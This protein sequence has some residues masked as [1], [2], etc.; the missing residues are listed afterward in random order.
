MANTTSKNYRIQFLEASIR[1]AKRLG[2]TNRIEE[3][4][5]QIKQLEPLA[6]PIRD[7][8][9]DL[10]TYLAK[11]QNYLEERDIVLAVFRILTSHARYERLHWLQIRDDGLLIERFQ[12]DRL[13]D[14]LV[15][16]TVIKNSIL[17]SWLA[18][19]QTTILLRRDNFSKELD[20]LDNQP[21][22]LSSIELLRRQTDSR[23]RRS[24]S[25]FDWR[26]GRRIQLRY[27]STSIDICG[28]DSF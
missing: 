13:Y 27:D 20:Y 25:P 21:L 23:S 22:S 6:T 14:K 24:H 3:F 8:M 1:L 15:D 12:S 28:R 5:Q 18:S 11:H 2:Q 16:E 26:I 19:D 9:H 7:Q 10:T 4:V 17:A